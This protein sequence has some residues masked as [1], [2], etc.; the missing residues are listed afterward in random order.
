MANPRICT[1]AGCDNT[2]YARGWCQRHYASWR[3][4]GD[5]LAAQPKTPE[6]QPLAYLL[7][8]MHDATCPS[9]PFSNLRGYARLQ[10]EGRVQYAHRVVCK[11][12][13][14]PPPSLKHEAAHNCGNGSQGCFR[15]ACLEWKT[16]SENQ[17]DRRRHGTDNRGSR[18]GMAR[19]DE[20]DVRTIRALRGKMLQREIAAQYGVATTT[21]TLIMTGKNWGWLK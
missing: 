19:L 18:H 15:A 21:I 1:V 16:G 5:P 14:G 12:V 7:A 13:N 11:M 4:H 17:A 20:D 6:G 9:W 10:Y 3:A 2:H 8:H